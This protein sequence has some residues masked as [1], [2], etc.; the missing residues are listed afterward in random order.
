MVIAS[1]FGW[2]RCWNI[3]PAGGVGHS[4]G[5]NSAPCDGSAD[6]KSTVPTAG[7]KDVKKSPATTNVA[8]VTRTLHNFRSPQEQK[9][10][11]TLR[12]TLQTTR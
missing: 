10:L 3:I 4:V 11:Q 9:L 7:D 12:K 8:E 6:N 2:P 1:V 5:K